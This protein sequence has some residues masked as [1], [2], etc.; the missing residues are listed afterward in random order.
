MN[1]FSTSKFRNYWDRFP[2]SLRLII[3]ARLWTAIGGVQGQHI[4]DALNT[5]ALLFKTQHTCSIEQ[6]LDVSYKSYQR[7]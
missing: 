1:L 5:A 7:K 2:V 4:I 6:A 3:K